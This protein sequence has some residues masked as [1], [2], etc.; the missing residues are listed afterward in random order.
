MALT[1]SR[2][3]MSLCPANGV[4]DDMRLLRVEYEVII[5]S[6][7]S[8]LTI[9]EKGSALRNSS[10]YVNVKTGGV[11]MPHKWSCGGQVPDG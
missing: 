6:H 5:V 2:L 4:V 3:E 10:N 9:F 1:M 11:L 7:R 8:Y